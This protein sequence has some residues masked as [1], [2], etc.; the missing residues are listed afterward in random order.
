[1]KHATKLKLATLED[2]EETQESQIQTNH[3]HHHQIPA[4]SQAQESSLPRQHFSV[5][6]ILYSKDVYK[7][8]PA[9]KRLAV[10]YAYL[11]LFRF[12]H[13]RLSLFPPTRMEADGT[14]SWQP[15]QGCFFNREEAD[16]D[17]RRYAHGYV[18]PNVPLGQSLT[19]DI[20]RRSSIYIPGKAEDPIPN[21]LSDVQAEARELKAAVHSLRLI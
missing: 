9:W 15:H 5:G 21:V 18:V 13:K 3:L 20:P 11:P 2:L 10:N 6:Q 4:R 19:K 12:L 7:D 8:Y 16:A 17:A 14:Y 1:M